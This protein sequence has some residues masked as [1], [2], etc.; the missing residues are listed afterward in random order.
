MAI[1]ALDDG[2]SRVLL[3][4]G[5]PFFRYTRG[6]A[7]IERDLRSNVSGFRQIGALKG[8]LVLSVLARGRQVT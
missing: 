6:W 4:E 5:L 8:E 2:L 7:G 1:A 3:R